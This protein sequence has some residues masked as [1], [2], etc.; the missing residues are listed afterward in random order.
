[1]YGNIAKVYNHGAAAVCPF[2]VYT[3]CFGFRH[4]DSNEAKYT[5]QEIVEGFSECLRKNNENGGVYAKR[6]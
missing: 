1:M 4:G 2:W 6:R 5:M 3:A